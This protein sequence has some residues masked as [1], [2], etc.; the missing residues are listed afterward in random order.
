MKRNL[1]AEEFYIFILQSHTVIVL[2]LIP[3]L[4]LNNH[5]NRLSILYTFNT[6]KCFYIDDAYT[7]ELDKILCD[8]RRRSY[9]CNL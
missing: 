2:V 8:I 1:V 9:K 4:K 6:V 7:S 3:V 5:I